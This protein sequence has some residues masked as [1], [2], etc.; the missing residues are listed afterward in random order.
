MRY[1]GVGHE[2]GHV[3]SRE[4]RE[5]APQQQQQ[6]QYQIWGPEDVE[7]EEEMRL[8]EEEAIR[9]EG[10]TPPQS[11]QLQRSKPRKRKKVRSPVSKYENSKTYHRRKPFKKN[12]AVFIADDDGGKTEEI[13]NPPDDDSDEDYTS[14]EVE[15]L[16]ARNGAILLPEDDDNDSG[17][18]LSNE[19]RESFSGDELCADPS[20]S[21]ALRGA[22]AR[23]HGRARRCSAARSEEDGRD[24]R[25]ELASY[26]RCLVT[27]YPKVR[28]V[29]ETARGETGLPFASDVDCTAFV[30]TVF[31]GCAAVIPSCGLLREEP[32]RAEPVLACLF[33]RYSD[34]MLPLVERGLVSGAAGSDGL[35]PHGIIG[36]MKEAG[37]KVVSPS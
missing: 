31:S 5:V 12:T 18:L 37:D 28:S 19:I 32:E 17:A 13:I 14:V 34:M 33:L 26:G 9:Q 35:G 6:Q 10:R 21:S 15:D 22:F 11:P 7:D 16:I 30:Q 27:R 24:V 4:S 36:M 25:E 3:I 8:L 23:C 2:G 1:Q 29:T 20:S